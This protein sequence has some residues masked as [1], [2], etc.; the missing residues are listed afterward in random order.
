MA[1]RQEFAKPEDSVLVLI[2]MQTRL[3][4]AI[5]DQVYQ[6]TRDN[7]IRL[8]H[9]CEA[10]HVPVLVTEQ[11]PS[12]LGATDVEISKHLPSIHQVFAKT[13]FSA[14]RDTEFDSA[15]QLTG[16]QKHVIICG[17][18]A[19]VC[20]LQT[21]VELRAAGHTVSVVEDAICSRSL[22]HT[23]NSITRMQSLGINIS[24]H[25]SVMFEWL[26]DSKHPAFKSISALLQ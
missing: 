10:L 21:A 18:E 2:D 12:G 16:K 7:A 11:Y 22:A 20:V 9:A 15:L 1:S 14:A 19:H 17:M 6:Q 8:L 13:C 3:A 4:V 24:N 23:Q 5:D 25:E 26:G